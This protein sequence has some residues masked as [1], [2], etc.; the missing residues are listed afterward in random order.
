MDVFFY[1]SVRTKK[2]FSI[3]S[4]YRNDICILK[5]LGYNVHL[6]NSIWD[7][8]CFWKYDIAFLYFYKYSFFAA[9]FAKLFRKKHLQLQSK[10]FFKLF[11][12]NYVIFCRIET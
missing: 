8:L 6:S 12:L 11:F 10:D 1:S 9:F 5:D 4:Y 7:F 3:Q 2:M